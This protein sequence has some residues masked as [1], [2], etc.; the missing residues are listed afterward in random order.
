MVTT[1]V[2]AVLT[3]TNFVGGS[4]AADLAKTSILIG[5]TGNTSSGFDM[6]DGLQAITKL[7]GQTLT[8]N[9]YSGGDLSALDITAANSQLVVNTETSAADLTIGSATVVA[10]GASATGAAEAQVETYALSGFE[11]GD[12]LSI[13]IDSNT[14]VTYEVKGTESDLAAAFVAAVSS[15]SGVTFSSGS[16]N[17]L[18]LTGSADADTH[19]AF[20]ATLSATQKLTALDSAHLAKAAVVKLSGDATVDE[21]NAVALL[22]GS[23]LSADGFDIRAQK[24]TV[25][26]YN[27][28]DLSAIQSGNSHTMVVETVSGNDAGS[29]ATLVNSNLVDA[30]EIKLQ[31]FAQ[32][33]AAEMALLL[34]GSGSE[35]AAAITLNGQ[36]LAVSG[37]VS[38]DLAAIDDAVANS[39][40]S[41][42]TATTNADLTIGSATVI[43][44]GASASGAAEAQKQSYTLVGYEAGDV[45]SIQIDSNTAVTYT[46]K[47]TEPDLAAA[48]VAAVASDNGVTFS[49]EAPDVLTL[50][51]SLVDADTHTAFTA[52]LSAA[53]SSVE[54]TAAKL[55]DATTVTLGGAATAAAGDASTLASRLVV[56]GK[57]LDVTSY[58]AQ[59]I[60]AINRSAA[61]SALVVTTGTDSVLTLGNLLSGSAATQADQL[62]KTSINL[63]SETDSFGYDMVNGLAARTDVKDQI[64]NITDYAGGNLSTLTTES[65]SDV[66]VTTAATASAASAVLAGVTDRGVMND[67]AG[68]TL[69]VQKTLTISNFEAGDVLKVKIGAT[70]NSTATYTVT[71]AEAD[72][73][74]IAAN[75]AAAINYHY[76][77]E[78]AGSAD[79]VPVTA[80][81]ATNVITFTGSTAGEASTH[82]FVLNS[83]DNATDGVIGTFFDH[84]SGTQL[85]DVNLLDV[86]QL[87]LGGEATI[88]AADAV[89]VLDTS[90][91]GTTRTGF[92][93]SGQQLNVTDYVQ[94]NLSAID[95]GTSSGH[96]MV[97]TTSST[98]LATLDETYLADATSIQI[99]DGD[100]TASAASIANFFTSVGISADEIKSASNTDDANKLTVT[101]YT[102]QAISTLADGLNLEVQ[103][104]SGSTVTL[105]NSNIGAVETISLADGTSATMT[106]AEFKLLNDAGAS[107]SGTGDLAITSYSADSGGSDSSASEAEE[108]ITLAN[109]LDSDLNISVAIASGDE[110]AFS[111]SKFSSSVFGTGDSLTINGD[112]TGSVDELLAFVAGSAELRGSGTLKLSGY[113]GQDLTPL[114]AAISGA[115][116]TLNVEL[117]TSGAVTLT[118]E[119]LVGASGAL[120]RIKKIFVPDGSTTT[121][122]A[123]LATSAVGSEKFTQRFF[124]VTGGSG[125]IQIEALGDTHDLSDFVADNSTDDL[126]INVISTEATI[127]LTDAKLNKVDSIQVSASAVASIAQGEISAFTTSGRTLSG[128]AGQSGVSETSILTVSGA[129]GSVA[130]PTLSNLNAN[131][132]MSGDVTLSSGNFDAA[133][134]I[135]MTSNNTF[136]VKAG[137]DLQATQFDLVAN[138]SSMV[139]DQGVIPESLTT[140]KSSQADKAVITVDQAFEANQFIQISIDNGPELLVTVTGADTAAADIKAALEANSDYAGMFTVESGTNNSNDTLTI[141]STIGRAFTV[142][143]TNLSST[144][145]ATVSNDQKS[146]VF[147]TTS[148]GSSN[149]LN[150]FFNLKNIDNVTGVDEVKINLDDGNGTNSS[151]GHVRISSALSQNSNVSVVL[152]ETDNDTVEDVFIEVEDRIAAVTGTTVSSTVLTGN[153]DVVSNAWE[154][155]GHGMVNIENFKMGVDTLN[156]IKSSGLSAFDSAT[157]NSDSTAGLSNGAFMMTRQTATLTDINSVRSK[158]ASFVTQAGAGDEFAISLFGKTGSQWDVGVFKVKW[159][160]TDSTEDVT[161]IAKME[162]TPLAKITDIRTSDWSDFFSTPDAIPNDNI[163]SRPQLI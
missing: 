32:A 19:T 159:N 141:N 123:D 107:F 61:G 80:A 72:I 3:K 118:K 27:N 15:D 157:F 103:V 140:L 162:I 43:A 16:A 98:E 52:S 117:T 77:T 153:T 23:N 95:S 110:A 134:V 93:I 9:D 40:L 48:F 119:L 111:A 66:R 70:G 163:V 22:A 129:D 125:T 26:G 126:T 124:E 83:S 33:N 132:E 68:G 41:V 92:V 100:A 8:I 73:N 106:A 69:P 39:A 64:L 7:N 11:A 102:G 1:G 144:G 55:D 2:D 149:E 74:E 104:G 54:L 86:K 138:G 109:G 17:V 143:L 76:G 6:K 90:T 49:S 59:D 161:N 82:N 4:N 60:A 5:D 81:A 101:G 87:T 133:D 151:T 30:T 88:S 56:D 20:S 145:A 35:A 139:V 12:V 158:I 38:Q 46:V 44:A 63:A 84:F 75:F 113:T 131:V 79:A 47:G 127:N 53:Q 29:A 96:S 105:T 121:L 146:V 114:L 25:T 24:L 128:T 130:L 21:T 10:A 154:D 78:G 108:D 136:S 142:N 51:G 91:S 37:Y 148:D 97:V 150:Q 135:S 62:S 45:L 58:V 18:T 65:A 14:A 13:Q 31:G 94:Q 99:G 160:D 147:G 34:D 112:L 50:T 85:D 89:A 155:H 28:A 42:T 137:T 36:Q 57:T 156:F 122:T 152:D 115:S 116:N 120:D 67:R 71:G